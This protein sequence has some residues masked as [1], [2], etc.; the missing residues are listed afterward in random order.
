[1]TRSCLYLDGVFMI[2]MVTRRTGEYR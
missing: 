1:M 2:R